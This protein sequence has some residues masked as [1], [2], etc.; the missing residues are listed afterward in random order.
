MDSARSGLGR[1][2]EAEGAGEAGSVFREP[3]ALRLSPP[4]GGEL[5]EWAESTELGDCRADGGELTEWRAELGE[6]GTI[7]AGSSALRASAGGLP[8]AGRGWPYTGVGL[9]RF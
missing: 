3:L 8:G 9:R 5:T 2:E 6:G 7:W 4:A 1:P